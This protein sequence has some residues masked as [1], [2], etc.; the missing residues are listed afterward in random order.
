VPDKFLVE[1]FELY[2]KTLEATEL[3]YVIFGHIGNNH[4]HV[5]ILPKNMDEYKRAKE[6][7]LQ[8]ARTILKWGGTVSGEHGIGKL[9][10][11]FLNLMFGEAGV[12]EMRQV[13]RVFDPEGRINP[14]NM[15]EMK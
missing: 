10:R 3:E 5:N 14:G 15:F 7:Y 2:R 4:V 1:M 13:K 6:I 11:P 8:L 9:K 12:E